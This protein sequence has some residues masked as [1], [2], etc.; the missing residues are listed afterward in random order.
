MVGIR[1]VNQDEPRADRPTPM[2]GHE[3]E[4][5]MRF[6][7][8]AL[9][10]VAIAAIVA[11]ACSPAASPATGLKIGLVTDVGTLN[12]KNFNQFSWE[13]TQDGAQ[14]IGAPAPQSAISQVSADIA[15]N[16]QSFVD[17]KYDI[18]VTVGFAAGS[19]TLK[20]AKANP[21]IK[22]IGV[23]QSPCLTEAGE[24]DPTFACKGDSAQ[25]V[26]NYIGIQWKEQQP[27]YLAGIV[28]GSLT[29]SG[30]I[31]AIGGT[32]TVPAVPNY[33]IGYANGAKSVKP[34]I[35]VE[36][37]Y[38]SAAADKAAFNDPPGGTAF[39]K[40]LLRNF[41]NVDVI[42]QVAGATGNGVLQ[43]A[44]EAGIYGIGVD[45]DQYVSVPDNAKC[46]IVSAEKKL[47]KNVSDVIQQIDAGTYKAGTN[48]LDIT[49]D[50]VGL[51][52]FH[53]HESLIT[54]DTKAKIDAAVAA[55][56]AGTLKACEE[57]PTGACIIPK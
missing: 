5:Q 12:D 47:K 34:D 24:A 45:V 11:S 28:A 13:G 57:G 3:R 23:D 50:D 54:A 9:T 14:K 37:Q 42:F 49:T 39:A 53:E 36:L 41:P 17:Q 10:M 38:V 52:S 43:A 55:M 56:K 51:S 26:P 48:R 16:I 18:I 33:M 32:I 21:N 27:G 22:F 35:K 20:A 1:P 25:L 46:T 4:V 2:F 8:L 31:A 6:R 15:K 44:C 29:K 7:P 19:D 30:H 40:L